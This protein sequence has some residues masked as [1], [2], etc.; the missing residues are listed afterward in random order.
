VLWLAPVVGV[1]L[2]LLL[3]TS[4]AGEGGE[5]RFP[6]IDGKALTGEKFRAPE[7]FS[8]P[9]NLL[10][11]AFLR[12][13]QE[14]VDTWIPRLEKVEDANEDFAF[15]EFPI[16]EK[17]NVMSR[18][19]IYQGMRGG[20][21]STRARSR[22]VSFHLDKQE[23]KRSLGI[24]SENV[25]RLFLVDSTGVVI[26]QDSGRWSEAKETDLLGILS[27]SVDGEGDS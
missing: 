26:W 3:S 8:K 14:D 17:M 4:L 16:L 15:Y 5:L 23:F 1:I 25:I 18:W 13:Q 19:F 11:V 9:Y 6:Y 22:T 27:P 21:T 10:L 24:D 20:I 12:K 2:V 7:D